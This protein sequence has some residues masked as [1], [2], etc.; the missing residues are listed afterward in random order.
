MR[1]TLMS[2]MSYEN[3][4]RTIYSLNYT[5]DLTS[6]FENGT[7]SRTYHRNLGFDGKTGSDGESE[8]SDSGDGNATKLEQTMERFK[9]LYPVESWKSE[10]F[11]TD[12]YLYMINPHWLQFDPPSHTAHYIL[13]AA[14]FIVMTIG[15]TGNFLVIFMFLRCRS[16][17]TPA[18]IL[19]VNL[20]LSDCLMLLKMPVFIYNSLYYGPA[21]GAAGCVVYGFAGGLTG[22]VSIMTL[23]A[24]A[25][26]RYYVVVHPL[27]P[28]RRTTRTRARLSVAFVWCY[29]CLFASLPLTGLGLNRYVPEGFL[30]SCSFDY[31]TPDLLARA[32]ILCFFFA[33]WVV[34]FSVIAYCYHGILKEVT[35]TSNVSS[36]RG[37]EQEKRRTELRLSFVVVGIIGLWFVAWTPYAVVALLGIFGFGDVITPLGSMLPALFCKSASCIDPFIYAVTN[38]RFRVEF[39]NLFHPTRRYTKSTSYYSRAMFWHADAATRV[40][41]LMVKRKESMSGEDDDDQFQELQACRLAKRKV[42]LQKNWHPAA[43]E[44]TRCASLQ[45][46]TN[47]MGIHAAEPKSS[48]L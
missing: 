20:A 4:T 2:T 25:L 15:V 43:T 7:V 5:N 35:N 8:I 10:G 34:P 14:Y 19:V 23:A 21:L 42:W 1:P 45:Y 6:L 48:P 9:Q 33:A 38:R 13:A 46:S 41:S 44:I 11:F 30:T 40:S 3:S 31:L 27:N 16:L 24:I 47:H 17:R 37:Q 39:S 12:E 29:G 28:L 32:F 22:T 26:D 36:R 18:N